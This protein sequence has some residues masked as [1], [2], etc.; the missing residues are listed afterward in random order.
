VEI[1]HII[2]AI[3]TASIVALAAGRR[4]TRSLWKSIFV[5][6]VITEV[7]VECGRFRTHIK[8]LI[9]ASKALKD[10][11]VGIRRVDVQ[12]EKLSIRFQLVNLESWDGV[13][14]KNCT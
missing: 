5:K 6:P 8:V 13:I 10:G 14:I 9:S 3:K 1:R 7:D 12:T 4:V 11:A 2:F